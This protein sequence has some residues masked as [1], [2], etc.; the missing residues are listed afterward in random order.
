MKKPLASILLGIS[1]GIIDVIPMIIQKLDTYAICSAFTQW[2]LL[3]FIINYTVLR[4]KGWLKGFIIA[5][6]ATIPILILVAK[7]ELFSIVPIAIMSVLLG[8][9]VGQLSTKLINE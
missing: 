7:T 5:L 4:I 3:G 9:L 1:A 8:A 6:S 2:I